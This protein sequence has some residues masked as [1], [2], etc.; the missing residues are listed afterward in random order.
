MMN[1]L[2]LQI[3]SQGRRRARFKKLRAVFS[4]QG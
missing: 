3:A 4:C 2:E 1:D